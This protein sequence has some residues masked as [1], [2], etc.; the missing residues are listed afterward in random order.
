MGRQGGEQ[1]TL[2]LLLYSLYA[3]FLALTCGQH[4]SPTS[5]LPYH[6]R[7]VNTCGTGRRDSLPGRKLEALPFK[8]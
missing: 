4:A 1:S 6:F 3:F 5:P 7:F 2:L 8:Q